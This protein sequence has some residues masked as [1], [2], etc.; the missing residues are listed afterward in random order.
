MGSTIV[1]FSQSFLLALL[2]SV[3]DLEKELYK[4]DLHR[5]P[6]RSIDSSPIGN[7]Q[8]KELSKDD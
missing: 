5:S 4:D 2:W 7:F 8:E 6:S 1:Q 3:L